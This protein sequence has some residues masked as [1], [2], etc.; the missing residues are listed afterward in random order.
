MQVNTSLPFQ[1]YFGMY[2]YN[3]VQGTITSRPRDL[4]SSHIKVDRDSF[5]MANRILIPN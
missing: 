5:P 4:Y 3:V 1:Y 2:M